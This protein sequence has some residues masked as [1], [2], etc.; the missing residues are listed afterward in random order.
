MSKAEMKRKLDTLRLQATETM[1]L[2][3]S[4]RQHLYRTLAQTYLTWRDLSGDE[5]WLKDQYRIA[6]IEHRNVATAP[7]FVRL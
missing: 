5:A 3:D 7:T 2:N 6:G 4:S 1:R